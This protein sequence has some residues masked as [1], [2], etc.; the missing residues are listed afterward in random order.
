MQPLLKGESTMKKFLSLLLISALTMGLAACGGTA[1]TATTTTALP[2]ETTAPAVSCLLKA[3]YAQVD[4][5][6]KESVPMNVGGTGKD[7]MSEGVLDYLYANC[8][9]LVDENGTELY[10]V[11]F[12]L[13]NLYKPLPEYRLQLAKKL[14]VSDSQLMFSASHTHSSV[15][16]K[17]TNVPSTSKYNTMLKQSL[18]EV[19]LLAKADAKEVTGMYHTA[20][21]TESLNFVR[22]YI[23][24]D[25]SYAGDN[26]GD[27]SKGYAAHETEGDHQLQLLKFTRSGGKDIVLT[28]F[29]TH[30]H[31]TAYDTNGNTGLSSDIV[32]VYR[33]ELEQQ[34]D[35]LALYYTGSS[36]N[37]NPTSKI[38]EEN[39]YKNHREHG[40]ALAAAAV[41]ATKDFRSLEF[42][43]IRLDKT[44]Y[45]GDCYHSEDYKLP[46]AKIVAE[47][48]N[49]G[50]SN[51]AALEGYRHLFEHS[52]HALAIVS[53]ASQPE[54]LEVP[55]YAFSVGQ[56][57]ACY[58][59]FELFAELGMSIKENSPFEAT[60]VC[61]YSNYIFSYMPTA[62]AFEHGG[63]G[64]YKSNFEPG[65][66]EILVEEFGK[67]LN[68]LSTEP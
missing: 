54:T 6:P 50:M 60:F 43:T 59:P 58:A 23:M 10:L 1:P 34:L 66:G 14:G 9:Y 62:L 36:G 51:S 35:C 20:T 44:V 8:I 29:Q 3:G 47:R 57:S 25:G 40:T 5:T 63:Y 11:A 68:G 18:E 15:N 12:D 46:E 52:R 37:V 53:R 27:S 17:A 22:R 55:L 19:A 13:C 21:Q 45:V 64:P 56:F 26:Y 30:P 61:C 4:I 31:R 16:I 7:G 39:V 28:N 67:L 24:K 65:T 41:A 2:A 48:Y 33:R 42:G 49:S 38:T 32:G